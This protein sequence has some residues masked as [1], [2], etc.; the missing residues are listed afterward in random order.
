MQQNRNFREQL[1]AGTV[2][3]IGIACVVAATFLLNDAL[4]HSVSPYEKPSV[5]SSSGCPGKFPF[6]MIPY[7]IRSGDSL[8]D[9]WESEGSP[10]T[11]DSYVNFVTYQ[12]RD[13]IGADGAL[14]RGRIIMLP[15]AN[16]D[17]RVGSYKG[18]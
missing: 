16:G 13:K 2:G 12:N 6:G 15:D 4:S 1:V 5:S 18:R 8:K 3:T 9:Y 14:E 11:L 17:C 7:V 10:S